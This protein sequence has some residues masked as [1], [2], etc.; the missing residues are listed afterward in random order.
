MSFFRVCPVI[1][2]NTPVPLR[3]GL[4]LGKDTL[5]LGQVHL[6]SP[7]LPDLLHIEDWHQLAPALVCASHPHTTTELSDVKAQLHDS[8]E[9]CSTEQQ[10]QSIGGF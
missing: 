10:P 2:P 3:P 8:A 4:P 5:V 1:L 9:V 7:S 6:A